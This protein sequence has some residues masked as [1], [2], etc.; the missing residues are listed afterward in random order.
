MHLSLG[1]SLLALASSACAFS[2]S[3]PFVFMSTADIERPSFFNGNQLQSNSQVLR[4]A[5]AMLDACP[6]DWY[7]LIS[8][9]NVHASDLRCTSE[10]LRCRRAPNLVRNAPLAR[11]SVSEVVGSLS[12]EDFSEHIKAACLQQGKKVHVVEHTLRELP[13]SRGADERAAVLE[14]ND[15]ELGKILDNAQD[16]GEYTA[17]YFSN[18]NKFKPYEA[19]FGEP[20]H[21]ELR[22]QSVPPLVQARA[23]GGNSTHRP[24]P[25]GLFQKYQFF[26]PGKPLPCTRCVSSTIQATIFELTGPRRVHGIRRHD[27]HS[28][29]PLRCAHGARQPA[30]A[31]RRLREGHGARGAEEAQLKRHPEDAIFPPLFRGSSPPPPPPPEDVRHQGQLG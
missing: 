21:M 4:S 27:N 5:K 7:L 20:V 8:Q 11:L 22:R 16:E 14:E 1:A 17:I 13:S 28:F 24:A 9:P 2:D 26:T 3:S 10:D 18:P 29:D 6:T 25:M 15:H 23:A 31:V 19:E 30:G 12:F